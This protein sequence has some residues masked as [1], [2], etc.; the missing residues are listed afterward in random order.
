[1]LALLCNIL[2]GAAM[3]GV[4]VAG[5]ALFWIAKQDG[6]AGGR[7]FGILLVLATITTIAYLTIFSRWF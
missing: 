5:V 6:S 2:I 4:F 1:M 7:N 3:T